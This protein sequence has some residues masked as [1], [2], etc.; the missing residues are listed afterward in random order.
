MTNSGFA[1][2][3]IFCVLK[4]TNTMTCVARIPTAGVGSTLTTDALGVELGAGAV[5]VDHHHAGTVVP[6]QLKT[7][8]AADQV[9]VACVVDL[10][11]KLF[12]SRFGVP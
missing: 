12:K 8:R 10:K 3:Q 7:S 5:G 1:N 9:H 2:V 6:L 4:R 11:S